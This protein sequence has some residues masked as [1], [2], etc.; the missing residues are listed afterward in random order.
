RLMSQAMRKLVGVV[1]KTKTCLIFINQVRE[2]I[3]V[4]FGNPEVTTGGRALKFAS[5]VRI[6]MRRST[7][8]KETGDAGKPYGAVTKVKVVKNKVASPF[9]ECE[10]EMIFGQGL[11]QI[12]DVVR[13]G[14]EIGVLEKS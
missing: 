5:S 8:L 3:G 4:V 12:H 6:E 10:P 11:S 2:K 9:R 7:L 13:T 1:A 14:A